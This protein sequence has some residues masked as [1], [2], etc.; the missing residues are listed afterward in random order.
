MRLGWRVLSLALIPHLHIYMYVF[1]PALK[2]Y[3]E[4]SHNTDCHKLDDLSDEENHVNCKK[5][6]DEEEPSLV[7]SHTHGGHGHS[8]CHKVPKTVAAIAWM[9]IIGDGIHNFS[10]GLAIGASFAESLTGGLS[11]SIAVF[12]HELPHEIG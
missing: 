12:C 10:D 3:A 4:E 2:N 9:V 5:S 8:H 11:T 6:T 1:V 7:L